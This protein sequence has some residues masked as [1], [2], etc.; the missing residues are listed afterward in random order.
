MSPTDAPDV[1]LLCT[2]CG[3]VIELCAF[4]ERAQCPDA[5]CARCLRIELGESMAQPH[6]RGG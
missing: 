3:V 4:C 1:L 6:A 2:R 5:I